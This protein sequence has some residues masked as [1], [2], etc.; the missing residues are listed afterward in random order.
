[1]ALNDFNDHSNDFSMLHALK[2]NWP[3]YLIE[4]WALGM[5]MCSATFFAGLLGLPGWPGHAIGDP[6]LR[7]WL[8]GLAMGLTAVGLIYSG[9]GRRSG[10]HMNPA[11]TLTFLFLKKINRQDAAWYIVFQCLG[12]AAAMLLLKNLFPAFTAAPEVNFVQTQP[13]IAGVTGAFIAEALISFGLVITVLYS[14]NFEKTAPF[15]GLFAGCLVMLYITVE[16]PFSGMSMNPARTLASSVAAGNFMHFWIY[17]SAPLL[18]MLSAAKV[19]KVWI[20]RKA[21]FRCGYHG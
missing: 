10:A 2:S 12:G 15:T 21:E 8:M 17:L 4:A 1:M 6:L 7:R 19:W 3:N 11:F 16:D 20:C 9:W 18:G 13:G 14:S 5:F